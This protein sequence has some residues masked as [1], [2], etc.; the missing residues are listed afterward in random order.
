MITVMMQLMQMGKATWKVFSFAYRTRKRSCSSEHGLWD[1]N[2][3]HVLAGG[4]SLIWRSQGERCE[5]L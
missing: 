2:P 4:G 3:H 1:H 5:G